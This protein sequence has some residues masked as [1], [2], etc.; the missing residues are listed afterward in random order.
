MLAIVVSF[1]SKIQR[2]VWRKN[3]AEAEIE[4]NMLLFYT[5]FMFREE[6]GGG[7]SEQNTNF[8]FYIAY[9]FVLTLYTL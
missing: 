7:V 5:K 2:I 4:T 9:I 8:H 1:S 3:F 6:V